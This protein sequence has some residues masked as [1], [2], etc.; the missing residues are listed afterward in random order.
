MKYT[1]LAVVAFAAG[2]ELGLTKDQASARRHAITEHPKRKGWYIAS[3]PLQLK[4]GEDF[5]FDGDLPKGMA[6]SVEVLQ[7]ARQA[8]ADT[9][10]AAAKAQAEALEAAT[11]AVTDAE[12]ALAAAADDAAKAAAQQALD[13]ATAALQALQA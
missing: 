9:E 4:A 3:G 7:K 5:Q 2:A 12:A 10:A 13:D 1:A 8:K 6:E 11:Q